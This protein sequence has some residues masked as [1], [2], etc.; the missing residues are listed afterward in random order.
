MAWSLAFAA[1]LSYVEC[2]DPP[3]RS[4]AGTD[5][6]GRCGQFAV[7]RRNV[8]RVSRRSETSEKNE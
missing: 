6:T 8:C 5:G 1:V 2:V 3:A 4:K 7:H